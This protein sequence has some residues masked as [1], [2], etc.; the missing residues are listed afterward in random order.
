M[1]LNDIVEVVGVSGVGKSHLIERAKT[2]LNGKI[3]M[4]SFGELLR[5]NLQ[6]NLGGRNLSSLEN[7]ELEPIIQSVIDYI[8]KRQPIV[9]DTHIVYR[10]NHILQIHHNSILRLATRGYIQVIADP[11]K[12]LERRLADY[13]SKDR[14]LD[15]NMDSLEDIYF[16]Q[17]LS[18]AV[19]KAIAQTTGAGF[20]CIENNSEEDAIEGVKKIERYIGQVL[21]VK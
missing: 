21:N 7:D 12:I 3:E 8:I 5:L 2:K 20:I 15:R 10:Q 19:V 6:G 1:K 18:L 17:K 13:K 11:N 4:A 14:I 16:E 9:L